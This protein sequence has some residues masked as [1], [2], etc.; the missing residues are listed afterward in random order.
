MP[1]WI[2]FRSDTVTL[3]TAEMREAMAAA[4]VGDDILGEDPTVDRLEELGAKMLGKDAGLFVVSGTMANQL[5]V[6]TVTQPGD[7]ILAAEESHVY[8]LEAGG[9]SALSGVQ[10]RTLRS[11]DGRFDPSDLQRSVRSP[12]IQFPRTR[13][14]CLENTFDLNRGIPLPP[15][16]VA[17]TVAAGHE[18]GLFCYLDGARLFNAAV[19][20]DVPLA[21]LCRDVDAVMVALTKGLAAP[22]GALL[23][24][25]TSFVERARWMRQRIGGGMRQAGHMAAAGIVGLETMLGRLQEDHR[26]ARRLVDGLLAIDSSLVEPTSGQTNVVQ[27]RFDAMGIPAAEVVETLLQRGIKIKLLGERACRMVTHW[28]I[29]PD[30]VDRAVEEIR[31]ALGR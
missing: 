9:A 8:N 20:L 30:E 16:Y 14:L 17:E 31:A 15:S 6:M 4:E 13:M 29:G 26:N 12:G 5:A 19:A 22:M 18:N 7:E 10:I 1:S 25:A 11:I 2:D 27:V 21:S 23:C 28:G 24:G 3:P